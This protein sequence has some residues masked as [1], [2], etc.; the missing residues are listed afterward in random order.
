MPA[1][2]APLESRHQSP[3]PGSSEWDTD[4]TA[5]L[6]D[7]HG[8]RYMDEAMTSPRQAEN[9]KTPRTKDRSGDDECIADAK[10]NRLK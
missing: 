10:E 1:V 9:N 7:W 5:T 8:W 6:V 3:A 2:P 4:S